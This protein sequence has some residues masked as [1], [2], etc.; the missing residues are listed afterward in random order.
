MLRCTHP[1]DRA[2]TIEQMT[3]G[4][5]EIVPTKSPSHLQYRMSSGA[6]FAAVNPPKG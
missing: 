2:L 4:V 6:C 1:S 3:L 5:A